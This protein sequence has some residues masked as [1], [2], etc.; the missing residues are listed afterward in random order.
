MAIDWDDLV[1]SPLMAAFGE[2]V[3]PL[4]TPQAAAPFAIDGVFDREYRAITLIDT[5][6]PADS[7]TPCLGVRLAQF[8]SPPVKG[9]TV[10]IASV[11]LTFVVKDIQPDS[12][13]WAKLLL[14]KS[15]R[16]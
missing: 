10:Y 1:L 4:Y 6:S 15:A 8:A 2:A 3:R 5:G 7:V 14:Q 13:G 16:Q 11:G 9:D 12:H